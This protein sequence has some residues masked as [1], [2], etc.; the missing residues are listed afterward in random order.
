MNK[1]L[2]IKH[3]N[4]S[5][6][7]LIYWFN[8]QDDSTFDKIYIEGKWTAG[9]HL[10]HLYKSTKPV[11]KIMRIP[12]LLLRYK[13]GTNNRSEKTFEALVKK[14]ESKLLEGRAIAPNR[15][16]T[17]IL[18]PEEK[19]NWLQK[20]DYERHL[21]I[22]NLNRWSEKALSKYIIPHPALGKLTMR[23][24]MY[25]TILHTDH[26]RMALKTHYVEEIENSR[27]ECLD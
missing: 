25:F 16:T 3:L 20:I 26:H 6:D 12:K 8:Q 13:F 9:Q 22:K 23:E 4:E 10:G 24:M 19:Q 27:I 5:F 11:N 15:F 2:I 21:L 14:Y 1:T 18:A 7:K 17:D